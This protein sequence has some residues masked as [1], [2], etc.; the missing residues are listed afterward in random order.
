[1]HICRN[2]I[3]AN[4]CI[5]VHIMSAFECFHISCSFSVLASIVLR[6][7]CIQL[8]NAYVFFS[9]CYLIGFMTFF[10]VFALT[11]HWLSAHMVLLS[12]E[13]VMILIE[14]TFYSFFFTVRSLEML[15]ISILYFRI[16]SFIPLS[17][18]EFSLHFS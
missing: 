8:E 6:H 1:M 5:W 3:E 9:S 4:S 7:M 14:P 11:D 13:I 17:R 15:M 18:I 10:S 12:H 16:V 2:T